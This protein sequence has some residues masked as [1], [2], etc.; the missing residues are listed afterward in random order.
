MYLEH[1]S[2]TEASADVFGHLTRQTI[3]S[4][5]PWLGVP[6]KQIMKIDDFG[7]YGIGPGGEPR[8]SSAAQANF[9]KNVT[10][11]TGWNT[12]YVGVI[13]W[14]PPCKKSRIPRILVIFKRFFLLFLISK[15]PSSA[16]NA[17]LIK[18]YTTAA[19]LRNEIC[20]LRAFSKPES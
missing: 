15:W 8:A 20:R 17:T 2:N 6:S 5:K 1:T 13:I 11:W 16:R 10:F 4:G 18:K 3:I 19:I 9:W 7:P 12:L 14:S